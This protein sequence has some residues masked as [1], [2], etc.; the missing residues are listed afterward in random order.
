MADIAD[1]LA[2]SLTDLPDSLIG[3]FTDLADRLTGP[4]ADALNG[5]TS[6]FA[7][8]LDRVAGFPQGVPGA[9]SH[10]FDRPPQALDE[11]W[12]AVNGGENA[13]HDRRDALQP[14]LQQGLR[15]DALDVDAK[16]AEVRID[17]RVEL[18]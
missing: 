18:D 4:S 12:I 9:S 8:V 6:A 13:V 15:L 11:L 14:D 7:Y 17:T 10:V 16:P 2:S 1:R 5:T 3:S